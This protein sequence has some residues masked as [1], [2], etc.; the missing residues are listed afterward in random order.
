MEKGD[1]F[2]LPFVSSSFLFIVVV[3]ITSTTTVAVD[4][5]SVDHAVEIDVTDVV[6]AKDRTTVAGEA[7]QT[8]ANRTVDEEELTVATT[9]HRST[10][11]I[12]VVA[13][14]DTVPLAGTTATGHDIHVVCGEEGVVSSKIRSLLLSLSDNEFM[15]LNFLLK[16]LVLDDFKSFLTFLDVQKLKLFLEICSKL[17]LC[18]VFSKN[19]LEC[20]LE[21]FFEAFGLFRMFPGVLNL[22][23]IMSTPFEKIH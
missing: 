9:V 19:H 14:D 12:A 16:K 3:T 7:Y 11:V 13:V 5:T 18:K 2:I 10:R 8:V 17:F 4:A 6:D 15:I 20:I 1:F 21:K 22:N 23:I